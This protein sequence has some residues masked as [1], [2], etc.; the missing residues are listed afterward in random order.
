[1]I[2]RLER[3]LN[4][5]IALRETRRPMSAAEIRERVA[6]YG[7]SDL[8][9]FRR[10]FERDKADLRALGVP[11]SMVPLAGWDDSTGYRI[12]AAAYDLPP[13]R[14]SP[15]ELAALALAL[16]ATGLA[17][18]AGA[19]L[20]KLEVDAALDSEVALDPDR[21]PG[22]GYRAGEPERRALEVMLDAPHRAELME[23][24]LTRTRVRFS[25]GPIGRPPHERTV[26]PHALVHRG[27]LWY[28]I[29]HDH[30]RDA[31]R[32]FRLDRIV[33]AVRAIGQPGSFRQPSDEI[34]VEDV[35]P[36]TLKSPERA[37]VLA[38]PAVA[39]HVARRA[40][41][42]GRHVEDEDRTAFT[43]AVGD[44]DS[45]VAWAL[46]FGPD[47]EVVSPAELRARLLSRARLARTQA[48]ALATSP[49]ERP[50]GDRS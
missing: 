30:D 35:L 44:P 18:D 34:S 38:T 39:W 25:Y 46:E 22:P 43:V 15:A 5:V 27:G 49:G 10:M 4:L 24:Q 13:V 14:L 26:D 23:A 20:R 6:G 17:G 37:E 7:Q 9:A 3:L 36:P 31:R 21:E 42:G 33:S 12:D 29:G 1:M 2:G 16:Q 8:S 40:L 41:G 19:G 11:I 48:A 28:L 32:A 45:F 50:R 47:L